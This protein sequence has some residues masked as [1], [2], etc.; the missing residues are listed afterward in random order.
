MALHRAWRFAH[1]F[2]EEFVEGSGVGL[3]EQGVVDML[4]GGT[5]IRQAIML[6]LSTEPGERVMRPD[7]GCSL[8]NIMFSPNDE[9]TAG[10]AMHYVRQAI[11][12]WEKRIEDL[13]IDARRNQ[14]EPGH[15]DILIR[16]KVR[17]TG[18]PDEFMFTVNLDGEHI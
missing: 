5:S 9:T 1:P 8:R 17:T 14:Q 7:Y 15:L 12:K 2:G 18:R 4:E 6:M 16:Y 13:Q 3:T 10:L 11:L